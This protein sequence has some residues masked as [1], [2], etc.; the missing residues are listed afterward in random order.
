VN[1][2]LVSTTTVR[3]GNN[4]RACTHGE[5]W[6]QPPGLHPLVWDRVFYYPTEP[7][8]LYD[9]PYRNLMTPE[10][11]EVVR[12]VEGKCAS[13]LSR[14][15]RERPVSVLHGDLHPW[16]VMRQ[17]DR[18]AVFDFEDLMIGGAV[19]DIAITLFYNR[20][21][22]DYVGLRAAFQHGYVTIRPWPVEYEGQLELLMA[23]RTVMFINYV[24]RMDFDPDEYIPMATERI[25]QVL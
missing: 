1:W 19:Q 7:V 24:L 23:A 17:R 15:H 21:H 25:R 22:E 10:R 9:E 5:A 2:R 13:E 3:L 20:D 11:T 16:N 12:A 4:R 6:Q 14:I 18:L 8:I